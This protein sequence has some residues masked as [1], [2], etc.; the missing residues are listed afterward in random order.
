MFAIE[1]K[2]MGVKFKLRHQKTTTLMET[3][4]NLFSRR[5]HRD[6]TAPS[7]ETFWAIRNV[8]FTV[9]E[10]ESLAV[11]GRNGAGKSTLLQ[12]LT[13]IYK[14]DEG[15]IERNGRVGLLQL[16]TG[17]HPEL[18]GRENIYLNGAILGLRKKEID[19][20]YDSIVAFSEL[21]RFIDTPIKNYSTGMVARLGFAI[22]INIKP[23]ILLID[24]VLAVGDES[25]R[26]KCTEKIQEIS[27]MG[28][29]II[30]VSHSM[31]EVKK[32]CNR[33][34]CLEQGQ[35]VF[36]GSSADA[37]DFYLKLVSKE[38]A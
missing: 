20:L 23:D 37:S 12:V 25:F 27:D 22:A 14:P 3:F 30:F 17:F 21:E 26:K 6:S 19:A 35:I 16:G 7:E 24:E 10:G 5:N 28:K 15:T 1:A 13:G 18:S 29:T 33:A 31:S 8:S 32:L 11:I 4:V 38:K 36:E 2:N 9:K 34:I